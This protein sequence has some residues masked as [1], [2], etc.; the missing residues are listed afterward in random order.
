MSKKLLILVFLTTQIMFSQWEPF[1]EQLTASDP[2]GFSIFF[3]GEVVLSPDGQTMA[4]ADP[5]RPN[6][7]FP[8]PIRI[9]LRDGDDWILEDEIFNGADGSAPINGD[10]FGGAMQFN[11]DGT[12]L[13]VGI[14]RNI[15]PT[16]ETLG[17]AQV[18]GRD[19]NG[20]WSQIGADIENPANDA[21]VFFGNAVSISAD[22]TTLAV[23]SLEDNGFTGAVY[24][25]R[26][27]NDEWQQFAQ[28]LLGDV[29]DDLF[30]NSVTFSDDGQTLVIGASQRGGANGYVRIFRNVD[31]QWIQIGAD[32]VGIT[33]GAQFGISVDITGDGSRVVI[34]ADFAGFQGFFPYALV[35]ENENDQ[36]VQVGQILNETFNDGSPAGGTGFGVDV[37]IST[38]GQFLAIGAPQTRIDANAFPN[39]GIVN[40]YELQDESWELIQQLEGQFDE[41]NFGDAVA[42]D[43]SGRTLAVGSVFFTPGGLATGGPNQG[44]VQTYENEDIVLSVD[45]IETLSEITAFP[46]PFSENLTISFGSLISNGSVEIVD[47]TGRIINTFSI[48][49]Q[50]RIELSSIENT[51]IYIVRVTD[52]DQKS[53]TIKVVKL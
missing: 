7:A 10:E 8:N 49:N 31:D 38:D 29:F 25:Y 45:S 3:G 28:T 15:P 52:N 42:L 32:I 5:F 41:E 43:D 39:P 53:N 37:N 40:L 46:N 18:Y 9:F 35:F 12:I 26:N 2:A 19:D 13:A 44:A 23:G 47:I 11:G 51:G 24:T 36:W 17:R 20:S 6:G 1:G 27:V 30:G 14:A 22:G 50:D 4:V 21:G 33:F 34:G 16:G 48:E